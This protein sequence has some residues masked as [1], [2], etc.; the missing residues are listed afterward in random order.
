MISK[1]RTLSAAFGLILLVAGMAGTAL[2]VDPPSAPELDPGSI[3]SAVTLA[4][5]AL[6]V[7]R[8]RRA[9]K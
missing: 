3:G 4:T 1:I 6:F 9:A 7:I 5:G 2:A 8:G